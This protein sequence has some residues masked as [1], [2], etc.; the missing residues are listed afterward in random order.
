VSVCDQVTVEC[1]GCGHAFVAVQEADAE[2]VAC[3]L[4][5]EWSVLRSGDDGIWRAAGAGERRH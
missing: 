3:G 5:L 2:C 4:A 1:P